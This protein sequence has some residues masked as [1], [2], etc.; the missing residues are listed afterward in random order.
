MSQ[1]QINQPVAHRSQSAANFIYTVNRRYDGVD[2]ML[3]SV[4]PRT[5]TTK[6]EDA[7]IFH[8]ISSANICI[9]LFVEKELLSEVSVGRIRIG[10]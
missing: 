9:N 8:D 4:K 1:P 3:K 5:W 7:L 10:A 2:Y 6:Q